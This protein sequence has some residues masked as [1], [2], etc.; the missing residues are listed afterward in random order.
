[1]NR[2]LAHGVVLRVYCDTDQF[3]LVIAAFMFY[4]QYVTLQATTSVEQR[5]LNY[6]FTALHILVHHKALSTFN[7]FLHGDVHLLIIVGEFGD[8]M[9]SYEKTVDFYKTDFPRT[10]FPLDTNRVLIETSAT[11]IGD[12]VYGLITHSKE[13]AY[14]FLPQIK[15]YAAK[16]HYHLRRTAKLDP[17]AEFFLYDL[18]YRNRSKFP[19][20]SPKRRQNFGY[21]FVSGEAV[22]AMQAFQEFKEM[23]KTSLAKYAY[24]AKFDISSYFNSIY[25]HDLVIW[26]NNI[27][28]TEEDAAFFDK[29]LKQ[30]NSGRS[31]DCLP[32]GLYPAKM[33]G[34]HFLS[35]VENASWLSSELTLRFMDDFYI[36]SNQLRDVRAD[37]LEIQRMLGDKGLSVN[38]SKT[39]IGSLLDL[40]FEQQ[41]DKVRNQLLDRRMYVITGSGGDIEA[42]EDE[43]EALGEEEVEYL[44][45]LLRNSEIEEE[46]AELVLTLLRD[47]GED[48][49]SYLPMFLE[50]FPNLS[51]NIYHFCGHIKDQA[52]LLIVIRDF[53]KSENEITEYQLFWLAKTLETYLLGVAGA[54]DVLSN[55]LDHSNAT[56]ISKAKILEIPERRYGLGDLREEHLRT[57]ASG[58][59][60]WSSAVGSRVEKKRNRNHLLSYFANGSPVNELVA[61]C[62][63]KM[64]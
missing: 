23:V 7:I 38:P 52:E 4:K 33:I 22:S 36:F 53:V 29:F 34:S 16:P 6:A 25:H 59:L 27:A 35:F 47:Y 60:S 57:G 58:W 8:T 45:D 55:L 13:S 44:M 32:H 28:K 61:R 39:K 46:D 5:K 1:M 63:Q 21:R 10:L 3:N 30:I 49:L 40:D 17:V 2:Y 31:I 14:T 42:Y 62:V 9:A 50:R 56:D 51:K 41:V 48:V 19:K 11:E 20:A 64:P 54:G 43:D 37:F 26:F 24:C 15:V 18:I 12:F